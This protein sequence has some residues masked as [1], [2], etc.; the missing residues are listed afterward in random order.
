MNENTYLLS[1][2]SEKVSFKNRNETPDGAH[3]SRV[4]HNLEIVADVLDEFGGHSS[5]RSRDMGVVKSKI[6]LTKNSFF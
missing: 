2:P 6:L 1:L 3:R 5:S 4:G